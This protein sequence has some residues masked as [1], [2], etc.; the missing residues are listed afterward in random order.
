MDTVG[1]WVPIGLVFAI[2]PF[3]LMLLLFLPET[4]PIKLR[5]PSQDEPEPWVDL[6]RKRV[7][8]A[9][10]EVGVSLQ[11][12]KN[13]NIALLLVN[14]FIHP[15]LFAAYSSTLSQ[16]VSKYFGWTL[17]QAS[18]RLSPPLGILNLA[19]LLLLPRLSSILTKPTGRFRLTPFSNDLFLTKVSLSFLILGAL[20]EGFSTEIVFFILGLVIGTLGAA[21][22]PLCRALSTSYVEPDQTSRLY[23]LTSMVETA[24]S[25]IGGPMLAWLFSIGLAR[26]GLWRGLPWFY[27][28]G[29]VSVGLSALFFLR[30]PK[31]PTPPAEEDD[32]SGLCYQSS[33]DSG[34]HD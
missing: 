1:P 13:P 18:Y 24:G 3:I 5:P 19:V 34:Y 21:N 6:S 10:Q 14:F 15:A 8:N 16:Y 29:L 11:L 22:G 9:A 12:I 7:R 32:G 4:L 30:R 25:L 2:T 17:A 23:G 26:G 33:D 27:V 28:A 31:K 20:L